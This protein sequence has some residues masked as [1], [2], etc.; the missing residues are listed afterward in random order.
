M[1][2]KTRYAT[3]ATTGCENW[4]EPI[5]VTTEESYLIFCGPCGVQVT[6]ITDIEPVEGTVLP[7][8]ILDQL[9]MQNSGD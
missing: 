9:A 4:G 5:P 1:L 7:Q 6:D 2:V 8:W 3:C